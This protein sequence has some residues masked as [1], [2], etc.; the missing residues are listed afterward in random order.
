MR[1]LHGLCFNP[2]GKESIRRKQ[3]EA[4]V[5]LDMDDPRSGSPL[6]VAWLKGQESRYQLSTGEEWTR[7]GRSVPDEI[8]DLLGVR[9]IEV[10][11]Q[12]SLLPQF[13][14][15]GID[16]AW[17]LRESSARRARS[18]ATMTLLD[19]VVKAQ[20][21][22]RRRARAASDDLRLATAQREA[23]EMGLVEYEGLDAEA[24]AMKAAKKK[25]ESLAKER[26][27]LA[28]AGALLEERDDLAEEVDLPSDEQAAA[29]ASEA[30]WLASAGLLINERAGI[31]SRLKQDEEAVRTL[32]ADLEYTGTKLAAARAAIGVC[33]VCGRSRKCPHCRKE[34]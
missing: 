19:L 12:F 29:L 30:S 32:A 13:H 24:R 2:S 27:V 28:E 16:Y 33:D 7:L 3:K 17:L 26:R 10:D 11:S 9:E 1:A 20:G 14:F 23:A 8:T 21:V 25:Y 15:Q 5:M 34:V 4:L 22:A 6:T 18:L 31:V